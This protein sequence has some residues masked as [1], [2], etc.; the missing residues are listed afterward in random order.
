MGGGAAVRFSLRVW[1]P[2][3]KM[4]IS[5]GI[6]AMCCEI[7]RI[8]GGSKPLA[9]STLV[10]AF[11]AFSLQNFCLSPPQLAKR[12]IKELNFGDRNVFSSHR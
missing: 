8:L 10:R 9:D 4:E 11:R 3:V 12:T 2:A 7:H 1:D 5:A 6:P